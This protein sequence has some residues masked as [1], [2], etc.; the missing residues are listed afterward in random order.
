MLSCFKS[1]TTALALAMASASL[2]VYSANI[3]LSNANLVDVEALSIRPNQ[4]LL[5]QDDRIVAVNPAAKAIPAGYQIVDLA[6]KYVLPG[7]I[8]SHVHHATEP[9]N[10]NNT[11]ITRQRLQKQLRGGVTSV[12][13]MAGDVRVLAGLKRSAQLGLIQ[14]PDIYYAVILG[15][16]EFFSDP[17]TA[18]AAKGET[19]GHTDWMRAVD[20]STDFNALMQRTLGTGASGIKIYA[21]VPAST[22][23]QLAAAAKQAGVKVW[24]H[25]FI[26][27]DKPSAV[28]AAGIEVISHVPDL[29]AEVIPDY[30]AWRRKDATISE[31]VKT[32]SFDSSKYNSLL[33]SIKQQGIVLDA[34]LTVFEQQ[35]NKGPNREL[36][37]QHGIFLTKLAVQYGIAIAA[38]TDAFDDGA[39][40]P[41]LHHEL[42]LLVKLAGLTPAQALQ[43]A[44]LNSAKAIGIED[45]VGTISAAKKANLLILHSNPFDDIRNSTDIAHVLK[46]GRFVYRGDDSTL[47]FSAAKKAG[48][49]LWLSGQLGNFPGTMTLAGSDIASQMTQTMDNIVAVLQEHQ[50]TT[51][52]VVKCTL[53]LADINDWAKA[54]EIYKR[55][56]SASLPA[57]SAFAASGLALNAK[58]ELECSASLQ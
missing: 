12:R 9:E 41:E 37:L 16:A 11:A 23:T 53:M 19:P 22:L 39:A 14:A 27:P 17:R 8:D 1:K 26:G 5:L 25:A 38:G 51:T 45:E 55:Y 15:G 44:T 13:D 31:A 10:Y 58:V 34:T 47:P 24:S 30:K 52:D 54:S 57:R 32:A 3:A 18:A 40:L 50:L 49:M 20:N 2:P 33:S 21:D 7:L 29:S 48:G 36:M 43:A 46:N 4:T 28:V 56:F 6:G 42:Q 35:R